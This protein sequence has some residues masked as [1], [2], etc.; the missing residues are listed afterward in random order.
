MPDE[1]FSR[2]DE[3][4]TFSLN[5]FIEYFSRQWTK[6]PNSDLVNQ[7]LNVGPLTTNF[8]EGFNRK[9]R[10]MFH[11]AHPELSH[12]LYVMKSELESHTLQSERIILHG[13]Q[14][15]L[16]RK[17]YRQ[18]ERRYMDAKAE[19]KEYLRN[20][21][22]VDYEASYSRRQQSNAC[23]SLGN[24]ALIREVEDENME[25]NDENNLDVDDENGLESEGEEKESDDD[26]V[27]IANGNMNMDLSVLD[28]EQQQVIGEFV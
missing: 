26:W 17:E 7:Y 4:Y 22:V 18:A 5:R 12:F 14:P 6:K 8:A 23:R 24:R 15:K 27:A 11:S 13:Q 1:T 21:D 16:R 10:D 9:L 3:H 28:E 19:L 25:A 2:E 20:N